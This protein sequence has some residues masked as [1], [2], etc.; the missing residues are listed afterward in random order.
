MW[1]QLQMMAGKAQ[2]HLTHMD[3]QQWVVVFVIASI[4]GAFCMRGFG[5]RTGY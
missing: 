4:I 1:Y 5:S 2:N 3:R